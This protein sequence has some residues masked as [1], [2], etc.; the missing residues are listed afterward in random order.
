M[1]RGQ[2]SSDSNSKPANYLATTVP[3][4]AANT[5]IQARDLPAAPQDLLSRAA[6]K[7][8]SVMAGTTRAKEREEKLRRTG[9]PTAPQLVEDVVSYPAE[10]DSRPGLLRRP[11]TAACLQTYDDVYE[12]DDIVDHH[13]DPETKKLHFLI[14]WKKCAPP[15][16]IGWLAKR[17]AGAPSL[18]PVAG[19]VFRGC[20]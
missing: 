5:S 16:G 8:G 19:C 11:E 12:I 14:K 15:R 2:G 13:V 20:G 17:F 9:A 1:Q 18:M 7:A 6:H 3:S 10:R 4:G